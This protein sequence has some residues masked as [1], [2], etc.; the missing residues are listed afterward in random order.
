MEKIKGI[1]RNQIFLYIF[2]A[3][4]ILTAISTFV[5]FPGLGLITS[6]LGIAGYVML[7]I[8]FATAK[9]LNLKSKNKYL[10][11]AILVT[12]VTVGTVIAGTV[13]AMQQS[14][15]L[16]QSGTFTADMSQE[17]LVA[18]ATAAG[19]AISPAMNVLNSIGLAAQVIYLGL[20]AM[21][22]F[23]NRDDL[24]VAKLEHEKLL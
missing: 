11:L 1:N 17:E 14:A 9:S 5:T 16:L 6:I 8:G 15:A 7:W 20:G 4:V 22:F 3:A 24:K 18:A 23:D 12:V 10:W 2:F 19:S 21:I 13:I